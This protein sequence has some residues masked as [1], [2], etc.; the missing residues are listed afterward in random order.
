V[1]QREVLPGFP[2]FRWPGQIVRWLFSRRGVRRM[3]IILAWTVTITALFYGIE[4]LRGA[5]AWNSY[6]K[7][8]EERGEGLDFKAF[9]PAP[10]PDEQNFAATPFFKSLFDHPTGQN[11][12]DTDPYS[13]ANQIIHT[14]NANRP[15]GREFID[16]V[17][18]GAALDAVHA[19]QTNSDQR[20]ETGR[21][22]AAARAAAAP[23]VLAGLKADESLF[24]ELHEA[25]LRHQSRY[26]INYKLDDPWGI[27]LPHLARIKGACLR[28]QL[29]ACAELASGQSE[30]AFADV[31]LML[32]LA[33]SLDKEPTLISYL[34][35][36]ACL[37]I[38]TQPV[39]EGLAEHRWTN[40]QLQELQQLFGEY[41]PIANL[42]FSLQAERSAVVLTADLLAERKYRLSQLSDPTPGKENGPPDWP[43]YVAPRGWFRQEQL[44]YCSLL[45]TQWDGVL[46]TEKKTI[47]PKQVQS[48]QRRVNEKLQQRDP[49]GSVV[50]RHD[51]LA[52][53]VLPALSNMAIRTARAQVAVDQIQ[54]ACALEAYRLANGQFPETLEAL[55]P[56]FIPQ[57]PHDVIT[58][59]AYKYRRTAEGQFVLY[60]VGWN[61]RDDGGIRLTQKESMDGKNGDWVW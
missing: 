9:I 48:N 19:G 42:K 56:R 17:A 31:K 11:L 30:Q 59:G 47:S 52:H 57:M 21:P 58:G 14:D 6:R 29:K 60:S 39:W 50:I 1:W 22:D 28:L 54:I 46:D 35:R 8:V 12:F 26:P 55:A 18:W 24:A 41:D 53:M 3:L 43:A 5:R 20:Y 15:S 25:S 23:H 44:S 33:D 34:V 10:V 32:R 13:Q 49:F 27:L 7:Q 45:Q 51:V 37:Q 16:L 40:A 38:A 4:N 61:E 36:T 2:P